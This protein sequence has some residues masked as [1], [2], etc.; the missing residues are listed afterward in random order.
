L[1][2]L[3]SNTSVFTTLFGNEEKIKELYSAIEGKT[4]PDNVKIEINT[5]QKALFL[6]RLN[7]VSFTIDNKLVVLIEHQSTV[8]KNMP[9]RAL[10]YIAELYEQMLKGKDIYRQSLIE[11]P[12]PEFIVL[13]NGPGEYP[14]K[15]QLK[16]S[17]AFKTQ[18][19]EKELELKIKVF[20]INK[21]RNT[22][23]AQKSKTLD[24][25]VFLIDRIRGNEK[26]GM[27]LED[28]IAESIKY[29]IA[30][31]I[32]KD[33]LEKYG[34]EVAGML[35]TEFNMDDALEI[36]RE[37]GIEEG[38]KRTKKQERE[39]WQGIVAETKAENMQLRS[40]LKKL[41]AE[42]ESGQA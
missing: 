30:N 33:Y 13:Y 22:E 9:L 39:K 25:Y 5:L 20:N 19:K 38:E 29:C 42:L 23:M 6:S 11:I 8:N 15:R 26:N 24:G 21:G 2:P 4:Y 41:R 35:Y 27:A 36:A 18:S 14:D 1:P 12:T 40:E 28:A 3:Q 37:E 32:L 10:L 17:D 16:L 31:G 7:D 34:S